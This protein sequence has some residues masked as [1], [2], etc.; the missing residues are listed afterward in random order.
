MTK[1]KAKQSKGAKQQEQA[2]EPKEQPKIAKLPAGAEG[3]ALYGKAVDVA[4]EVCGADPDVDCADTSGVAFA[5]GVYDDEG[6]VSVHQVRLDAGLAAARREEL[7]A[8]GR[9]R[10]P[11][12]KDGHA[13][14]LVDEEGRVLFERKLPIPLTDD[15]LLE[16]GDQLAERMREIDEAEAAKKAAAS[17]WKDRIDAMA[18]SASEMAAV[19]RAK[20]K[21]APVPCYTEHD[22]LAE[23]ARV[24][25]TDTLEV[26]ET[27]KLTREEIEDLRQGKLFDEVRDFAEMA[28]ASPPPEAEDPEDDEAQP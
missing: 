6:N 19:L 12:E 24:I 28:A 1:Q 3:D 21:L 27:R 10:A 16:L 7:K 13:P 8:S 25:R 18:A 20:T 23:V 4:C 22:L 26:V 14:A 17:S 9:A 5:K 11:M 15:E 2:G